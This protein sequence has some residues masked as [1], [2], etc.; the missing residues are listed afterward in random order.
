MLATIG[1]L[2]SQVLPGLISWGAKKIAGTKIGQGVGNRMASIK[3]FA[4]TPAGKALLSQICQ[5]K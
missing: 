4:K 1:N 2:A 3:R 5:D